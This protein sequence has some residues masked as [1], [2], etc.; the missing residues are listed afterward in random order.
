M[1]ER[2]KC[3]TGRGRGE[4]GGGGVTGVHLQMG[5]DIN[6]GD[7]HTTQLPTTYRNYSVA[8]LAKTI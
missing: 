4:G 2:K 7:S 3:G 8:A 5:V 6:G 1:S